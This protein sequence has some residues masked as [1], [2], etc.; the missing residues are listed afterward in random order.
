[1]KPSNGTT[2]VPIERP[3]VTIGTE[4]KITMALLGGIFLTTVSGT[5]W[6]ARWSAQIENRLQVI[7][8]NTARHSNDQWTRNDM[9]IWTQ[10]LRELN[11][12]NAIKVPVPLTSPGG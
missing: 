6:F 5:Y 12:G 11:E 3:T 9:A 4:S 2:S 1:M 10:R 7:E 8:A